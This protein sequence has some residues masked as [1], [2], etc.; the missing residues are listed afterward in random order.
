MQAFLGADEST[1]RKLN[2]IIADLLVDFTSVAASAP[3]G[4]DAAR[5]LFVLVRALCDAKTLACGG[6]YT[7]F[8]AAHPNDRETFPVE[9]RAA[10]VLKQYLAAARDLDQKFKNSQRGEV[11]PIGAKLFEFGARD[12]PKSHAV[13][14]F[15]LGAFGELS[16]SCYSLCHRKGGRCPRRELLEDYAEAR[17]RALKAEVPALLVKAQRG[18]ARRILVRFH[19]LVLSPGDS[20][21][22]TREPDSFSHEHH[23]YFF[24]RHWAWHRHHFWFRLAGWQ[25]RLSAH[26]YFRVP[27]V[28]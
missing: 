6:A 25:R 22:A 9:K 27:P 13:V 4:P 7:P 24:F 8:S 3:D 20:T 11:G 10:K 12:G 28:C 26:F 2:G 21:A 23:I 5:N 1:Q 17:P 15:V 14:G 18:W 16:N 19:D